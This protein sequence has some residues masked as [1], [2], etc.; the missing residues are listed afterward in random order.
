M[1]KTLLPEYLARINEP[2]LGKSQRK[3]SKHMY[4]GARRRCRVAQALV[5]PLGLL[6]N[7][8]STPKD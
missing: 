5:A 7:I 3:E 6:L 1:L 4:I 2:F 8:R